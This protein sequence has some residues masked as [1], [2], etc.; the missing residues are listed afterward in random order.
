MIYEAID[1]K[2]FPQVLVDYTHEGRTARDVTYASLT[3]PEVVRCDIEIDG[4]IVDTVWA[5]GGGSHSWWTGAGG[6]FLPPSVAPSGLSKG[7]R[8]LVV[9]T[10]PCALRIDWSPE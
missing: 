10:G 3:A 8:L 7:Q 1:A 2:K 9:V 5:G 6:K 4:N